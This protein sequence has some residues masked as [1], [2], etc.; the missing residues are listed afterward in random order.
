MNK[1][2]KLMKGINLMALSFPFIFAGPTLYHFKGA[3]ALRNNEPWWLLISLVLMLV[4]V[5]FAVRGLRT[6]MDAFFDKGS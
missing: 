1:K 6:I 4:A 5:F 3:N 2:E